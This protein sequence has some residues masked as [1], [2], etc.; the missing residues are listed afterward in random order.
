MTRERMK[1]IEFVYKPGKSIAG[2]HYSEVLDAVLAKCLEYSEFKRFGSA[3]EV[4]DALA[5]TDTTASAEQ[6]IELGEIVLAKQLAI[7][8]LDNPDTPVEKRIRSLR[9]LALAEVA[10]EQLDE[11]LDHYKQAL[12]LADSS[13]A[14][15]HQAQQYNEL[16]DGAVAIYTQR[17]QAGQAR[18]MTKKRK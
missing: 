10:E 2:C 4:V 3:R 11:A 16:V 18:L 17:G 7:Q 1:R 9:T 5:C 13:G 6:A 12:A 15:F 8:A 14:Y